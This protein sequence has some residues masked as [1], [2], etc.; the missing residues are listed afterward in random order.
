MRAGTEP[1]CES[2]ALRAPLLFPCCCTW[3]LGS[4][5]SPACDPQRQQH[6][7]SVPMWGLDS[8]CTLVML[9]GMP[10]FFIYFQIT[11]DLKYNAN[12]V[13]PQGKWECSLGPAPH[14][15]LLSWSSEVAA[16]HAACLQARTNVR[17][18]VEEPDLVR[19]QLSRFLKANWN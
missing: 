13:H 1:H 17:Y 6:R 18:C 15:A 19:K 2:R 4:A 9:S 11:R 12:L 5:A 3:S 10:Q 8:G 14:L 16:S 7:G